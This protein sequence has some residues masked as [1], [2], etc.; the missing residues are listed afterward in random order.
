MINQYGDGTL[1]AGIL[2]NR[3]TLQS[4]KGHSSQAILISFE[5]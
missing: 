5:N 1:K 3:A 4:R 2:S